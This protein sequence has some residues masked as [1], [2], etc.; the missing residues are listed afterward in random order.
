MSF[1]LLRCSPEGKVVFQLEDRVIKWF[2]YL[3][4]NKQSLNDESVLKVRFFCFS[5]SSDLLRGMFLPLIG[6]IR[7]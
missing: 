5:F 1:Y 2:D 6:T 3:W 7:S 4:A